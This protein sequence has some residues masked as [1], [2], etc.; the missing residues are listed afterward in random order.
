MAI[1]CV[2]DGTLAVGAQCPNG[3]MCVA[4]SFCAARPEDRMQLC[5]KLCDTDADCA[6]GTCMHLPLT[7][8]GTAT[9]AGICG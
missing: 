1:A 6:T 3:D 5:R 2:A 4:G 7:F 9:T 8:C